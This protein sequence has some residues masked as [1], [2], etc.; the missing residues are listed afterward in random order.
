ML[1][2]EIYFKQNSKKP[3]TPLFSLFAFSASS[4]LDDSFSYSV[5]LL[6]GQRDDFWDSG[7]GSGPMVRSLSLSNRL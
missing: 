2:K 5:C 7:R 3:D 6:F 4:K 1:K